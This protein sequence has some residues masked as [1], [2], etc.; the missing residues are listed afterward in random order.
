MTIDHPSQIDSLCEYEQARLSNIKK[1]EQIL[2]DL[3]L[4]K[5]S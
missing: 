2:A 5:V 3:G 4:K 1:N